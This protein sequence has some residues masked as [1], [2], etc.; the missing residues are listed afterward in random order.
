MSE[1]E[2]NKAGL[3]KKVSS[4]FKGVPLPQG[5]AARQTPEAPTPGQI[6]GGPPKPTAPDRQPQSSLMRKLHQAEEK[7]GNAIVN[8]ATKASPESAPVADRKQQQPAAKE[9]HETRMPL[10]KAAS[11]KQS[12]VTPLAEPAGPNLW[13]QINDKLFAPK[14]GVSPTRQK[15][16]VILIPILAI[17]MIFAF[18][19]VL[20]TSPHKT[21]AA[22]GDETLPPLGAKSS[23]QIDWQV[24]APLPAT[25]RDPI[26]LVEQ[27]PPN[28]TEPNGT[29]AEPKTSV[30]NVRD[31]IYSKD[32]PS[33]F[34][35]SRIVHVGDKVGGATIIQI[36]KNSIEFEK[37]GKKWVKDVRD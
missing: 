4:V 11:A 18:R 26:K 10:K 36:T 28:S 1:L 32:K 21:Q 19:Q 17:I 12:K 37:N 34:V 24:P 13:R 3:Q 8:G 16:M 6:P 31:I 35:N 2:K 30:I 27:S 25:M 9:I 23:G 5:S 20:S 33:A 22:T 29:A 7:P 15:A 14:P